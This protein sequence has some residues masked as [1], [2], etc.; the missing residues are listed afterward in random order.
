MGQGTGLGL[1][2]VFGFAKQSQ[3]EV[4]V[5]STPGSDTTFTLYLPRSEALDTQQADEPSSAVR[6]GGDGACVLVVEDNE[7]VG[8]FSTEMLQDLGYKTAWAANAA[9]ALT[10]LA[11]DPTGFAVIFSDIV[12]PGMNGIDFAKVVRARY[13]GLPVVLTSGYSEVVAAEG[14]HGFD[15]VSKPYSAEGLSRA[16]RKAVS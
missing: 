7:S 5:E 14:A 1:S 16:L 3:G 13:P 10:L 15:L 4:E 9:D 8:L 12:M 11:H 2:Q 6:V